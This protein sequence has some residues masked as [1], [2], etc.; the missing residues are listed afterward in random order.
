LFRHF[1]KCVGL[2]VVLALGAAMPAAADQTPCAKAPRPE[3]AAA[4]AAAEAWRTARWA[5]FR[6]SWMT[7]YTI[8]APP[9]VPFAIA[10]LA[11]G[12]Q[13]GAPIGPIE[14]ISGLAA[15]GP[16]ACTIE[17]TVAPGAPYLITFAARNVRFN[18]KNQGWSRPIKT[19]VLHVLAVWRPAPDQ[20]FTVVDQPAARTVVIPGTRLSLPTAAELAQVSSAPTKR[21]R[22]H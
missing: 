11:R 22:R 9:P 15:T 13:L 10:N 6:K 18:E 3:H 12:M 8:P 20:P 1:G 14:A 16:V 17:K 7:S 2:S 5:P 4:V 21:R 19:A